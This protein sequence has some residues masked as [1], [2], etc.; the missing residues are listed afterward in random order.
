MLRILNQL[1]YL[2]LFI[3]GIFSITFFY[4]AISSERLGFDAVFFATLPVLNLILLILFKINRV[5]KIIIWI[6]PLYSVFFLYDFVSEGILPNIYSI[7]L[8][9]IWIF[10]TPFLFS[11]ILI[12]FF[13]Y[14][15]INK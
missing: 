4:L 6:S 7:G 15:K 3:F 10:S 12:V 2:Y 13:A 11:A 9:R 8:W 14:K 5:P 1:F